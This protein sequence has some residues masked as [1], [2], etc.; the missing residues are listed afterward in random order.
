[1][2]FADAYQK[3]YQEKNYQYAITGMSAAK[4]LPGLSEEMTSQLN[5]WHGCSVYQ[6]AVL[7]QA[8]TTV[9]TAQATLPQFRRALELLNQA[10]AY[11][12]SVGVN[13]TELIANVNTYV[14]IQDAIIKRGL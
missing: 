2:I 6:A 3:G 8:P 11:P 5:F 1:M 12:A 10:G 4:E 14:E 13:L 9:A 7:Q